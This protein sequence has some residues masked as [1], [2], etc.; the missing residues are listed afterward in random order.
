VAVVE[1]LMRFEAGSGVVVDI[2]EGADGVADSLWL[3]FGILRGGV[4]GWF[5]LRNLNENEIK[6]ERR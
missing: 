4:S 1:G 6:T 3:R 5:W 2:I